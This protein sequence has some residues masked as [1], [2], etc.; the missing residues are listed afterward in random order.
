MVHL[1]AE[2]LLILE[3]YFAFNNAYPDRELRNT[4]IR[5]MVT[6][7]QDTGGVYDRKYSRL[8]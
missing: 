3:Y 4:T 2:R 5:Q 7:F 1:R 6:T 8:T